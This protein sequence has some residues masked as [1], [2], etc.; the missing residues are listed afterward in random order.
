[1]CAAFLSRPAARPTR[2]GKVEPHRARPGSAG[3]AAAASCATPQRARRRRGC[4]TRARARSRGRARTAR[5][6]TAGRA[7]G[8]ASAR[9]KPG[10]QRCGATG[11]DTIGARRPPAR[12]G[13]AAPSP[14][15]AFAFALPSRLAAL[16][17]A[18][19]GGGVAAR[20]PAPVR[21][22]AAR[23]RARV[24]RRA[25]A[26]ST[27]ST[28]P[29]ASSAGFAAGAASSRRSSRRCEP[30]A[31]RAAE[32]VRVRA[33]VPVA[34]ARIDAGV[35]F[36]NAH[37]D[38][39]ARAEATYGVPPEIIVAIIGVET[40]Y[41][42]NTGRLPRDRRAGDAGVRLSAPRAVLPRRAEASSCCSRAS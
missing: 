41:G 34:P 11:D 31:A 6:G 21:L 28:A 7:S 37:A 16:L 3:P 15:V 10:A 40:F 19:R 20:R 9:G 5:G 17:L 27:A 18:R 4:R 23:R 2:F 33:A 38:A 39:L 13:R 30:T 14:A 26:R 8:S 29:D 24:H 22:R 42:R 36:W 25:G 32:V 12:R 35:A 1:M